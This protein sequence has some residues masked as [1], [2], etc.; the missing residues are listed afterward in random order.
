MSSQSVI[1]RLANNILKDDYLSSLL[2]KCA[3][4]NASKFFKNEKDKELSSKEFIDI[5]RFADI[6][7]SSDNSEARNTAYDIISF[8]FEEYDN[9]P[10]YKTVSTA[11]LA[12]I[13]NFPALQ[14][15]KEQ[16]GY[17]VVLP[18]ERQLE[19]DIKTI[20]QAVPGKESLVFTDI[21]FG[22]FEQLKESNSFSFSG[23]TSLGKS[24]IIRALIRHIV[25]HNITNIV[26]LVPTRA[27]INQFSIDIKNDLKDFIIDRN[28]KI[29]TNSNISEIETTSNYILVLTPERF[30]T[31]LATEMNPIIDYL[32]V[33]EAQ[34]LAAIKDTRSITY[35]QVIERALRKYPD[36]RVF[37][38]SPNVSNPEIFLKLFNMDNNRVFRTLET[39]VSQ[40]LY[41][42]D[43]IERVSY[44]FSPYS[45][46]RI[47]IDTPVMKN[48]TSALDV[49]RILGDGELNLV[50]CNSPIDTIDWALK[51]SNERNLKELSPDDDK[52]LFKVI[53]AIEKLVHKDYFLIDCLKQ[54]VAF[55]FGYLPQMIRYQVEELFKKGI[56]DHIFCTSTLLEGVNL[57]AKNVFILK[58]RV[59]LNVFRTIDFRNL[60]GRAG[61]LTK[62]MSG[63]IICVKESS[64]EWK[65]KD[66]SVLKENQAAILTPSVN[67][68]ID[69]NIDEIENIINNKDSKITPIY[70][71]DILNYLS[72]IIR[73]YSLE[74]YESPI[75]EKIKSKKEEISQLLKEKLR[76]I[77][78]PTDIL[79]SNASISVYHQNNVYEY[80]SSNKQDTEKI[81]LPRQIDFNACENILKQFYT[82]FHWDKTETGY[83]K[84]LEHKD[85]PNRDI[86][87]LSLIMSEWIKGMPLNQIINSSIS[88]YHDHSYYIKLNFTQSEQ[89]SKHNRIHV[90]KLINT[91]IKDI[92][93]KLRFSLEKYFNN[94]Y[95]ILRSVLGEENAGHNWAVFLEYGTRDP[96]VI[97]LQNVGFSRHLADFVNR[98]HQDCLTIR[99]GRLT[100]VDFSKLLS[101]VARDST[102]H[103]E[104][105]TLA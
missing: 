87:Y 104:I 69:T 37:F 67:H 20:I 52:E 48:V 86:R 92:E 23:P 32:F 39:P 66:L 18:F 19:R 101:S 90:N 95:L 103:D 82:F 100:R 30:S 47:L 97:G 26:V 35:Y 64:K 91:L 65:E 25:E 84:L 9:D 83:K 55:H 93:S 15:L 94:Y 80:I 76:D 14:Y 88:H 4:N 5:L 57:P 24:F 46:E 13:G 75:I 51:Y 22:L 10:I 74:G 33:D 72:N 16:M 28:Y 38:S 59:S 49:V 102:E 1:D 58:N 54:R 27:L 96:I 43:L 98:N 73:I 7:S 89:F 36:L 3:R 41:F 11:V 2:L 77:I 29:Q 6:L 44:L 31:Y 21:Q 81:V 40:H 78:V 45:T 53:K 79:N 105:I 71:R 34:K 42:I 68:Q 8:L 61:R 56:I 99:E 70:L 85:D 62:E 12:R 17:S 50:Y 60:A 63:N